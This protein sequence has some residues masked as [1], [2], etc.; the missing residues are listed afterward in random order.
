MVEAYKTLPHPWKT[1]QLF[2]LTVDVAA[3][4]AAIQS[5]TI[6][7]RA[8][9]ALQAMFMAV[10]GNRVSQGQS[11]AT[12]RIVVVTALLIVHACVLAWQSWR[13]G[14]S[15]AE[16]TRLTRGL[17][18]WSG[19][20]HSIQP[21]PLLISLV[22]SLPLL[23][24]DVLPDEAVGL[25]QA[26]ANTVGNPSVDLDKTA[27]VFQTRACL[28][29]RWTCIALSVWGG[30]ICYRW[31]SELFGAVAGVISTG[32]WALWPMSLSTSPLEH[33]AAGAAPVALAAVYLA[34]RWLKSPD[35][36]TALLAGLASGLAMLA[37]FEWIGLGIALPLLWL[38]ARRRLKVQAAM[39][40]CEPLATRP[41]IVQLLIAGLV[42]F[43]VINLTFLFEG[44][45]TALGSYR[46]A[47][48]FLIGPD[49]DITGYANRFHDGVLGAVPIP[50]PQAYVL[51]LDA[52]LQELEECPKGKDVS[53]SSTSLSR[54]QSAIGDTARDVPAPFWLLGILS[55]LWPRDPQQTR[56]LLETL[57]LWLP[58]LCASS[59]LSL[60][61]GCPDSRAL[62]FCVIPF[63]MVAVSRV[64]GVIPGRS[65]RQVVVG[66]LLTWYV[67]GGLWA[68]F[69]GDTPPN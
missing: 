44:T 43:Y 14:P 13:V 57:A 34:W 23:A 28:F 65:R 39:G 55:I 60:G 68:T 56:L 12:S 47:S 35:W 37:G 9:L 51:S 32:L 62:R 61:P 27:P 64:G 63:S 15:E 29:G 36:T 69:G 24:F 5:C 10:N 3:W 38:A 53:A 50:L 66:V 30:W 19:Q 49:N 52:W 58:M 17:Q 8:D 67:L 26:S 16:L 22:G 25:E 59:L 18:H 20:V 21:A 2:R 1:G 4:P 48:K 33:T 6:R 54:W 46:F 42:A 7:L 40:G 31:G 41:T 11:R 45:L